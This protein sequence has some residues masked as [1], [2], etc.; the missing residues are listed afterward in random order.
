[1]PNISKHLVGKVDKYQGRSAFLRV[2]QSI[3]P[4][5]STRMYLMYVSLSSVVL[6]GASAIYIGRSPTLTFLQALAEK[7]INDT[8]LGAQY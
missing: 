6:A 5:T 4:P 1:M 2:D 3:L 7:P 8:M